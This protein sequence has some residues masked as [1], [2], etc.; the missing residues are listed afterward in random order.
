MSDYF[1][2]P[3]L[4][5]K[6]KK[7]PCYTCLVR[8][9]CTEYA[10][11]ELVTNNKKSMFYSISKGICPDCGQKTIV[12]YKGYVFLYKCLTCNHK[13]KECTGDLIYRI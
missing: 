5:H 13:F 3:N 4:E 8:A 9:A 10:K 12:S 11:C 7:H 6:M 2:T 1:D